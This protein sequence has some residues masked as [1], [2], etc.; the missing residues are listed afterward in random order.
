MS[1]LSSFVFQVYTTIPLW[2][3]IASTSTTLCSIWIGNA[4]WPSAATRQLMKPYHNVILLSICNCFSYVL[5]LF[6]L[7]W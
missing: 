4:L 1:I 3:T 6:D 2:R 7:V 5:D